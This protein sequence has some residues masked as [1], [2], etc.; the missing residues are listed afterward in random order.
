MKKTAL[1]TAAALV[2]GV[3][4]IAPVQSQATALTFQ[5]LNGA[6]A[7]IGAI[8]LDKL[9]TITSPQFYAASTNV[10]ADKT[11]NAGD[12]FSESITLVTNSSSLGF[13][14][15]QFNLGGDYRI[16]AT[17]TGQIGNTSGTPIVINADNSVTVGAD[18]LFDVAFI[19]ATLLLENNVTGEDIAN[20]VFV[21]GG[22]SNIQLV[23]G[24][25]I[26]DVEINSLLGPGCFP[27]CDTYIK[28]ADGVTSIIG[29]EVVTITTGS[30]R[31]LSFVG[32][33]FATNT[34]ITNFQDNGESTT[35]LIPEPGSLAL[36]GAA[37]LGL[38]GFGR[39]KMS[40]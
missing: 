35:F 38:G 6:G 4:A 28:Q 12:I 32:S 5:D 8:L 22:G 37:L 31:F 14:P 13:N 3:L 20:L 19:N 25:L 15:V 1:T 2:A 17:L 36:L 33:N 23:V 39:R 10:G 21:S 34:L 30:A 18:S 7:P 40:A 16:T 29:D 9:N 11:L 24:Q 27:A 26:G